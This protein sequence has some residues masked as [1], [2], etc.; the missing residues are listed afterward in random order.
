MTSIF[1]EATGGALNGHY[2]ILHPDW[3]CNVF[4]NETYWTVEYYAIKEYVAIY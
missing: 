2:V 3:C 4:F 1:Y